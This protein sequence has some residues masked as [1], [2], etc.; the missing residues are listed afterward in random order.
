MVSSAKSSEELKF[1]PVR[2]ARCSPLNLFCENLRIT[3]LSMH[4]LKLPTSGNN[5]P[6]KGD[7]PIITMDNTEL[8]LW[9]ARYSW[10]MVFVLYSLMELMFCELSLFL[11][12]L[13]YFICYVKKAY[14]FREKPIVIFLCDFVLGLS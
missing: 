13:C 7:T 2:L 9:G 4:F 10:Y 12:M 8:S 14:I 3:V 11:F 6:K 1:S 5:E